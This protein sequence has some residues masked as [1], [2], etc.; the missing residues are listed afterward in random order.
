[1]QNRLASGHSFDEGIMKFLLYLGFALANVVML[2][3]EYTISLTVPQRVKLVELIKSDKEAQA[4]FETLKRVADKALDD[5]P[6]PIKTIQ[7]EGK[8]N[9]DPVKIK[10]HESLKDTGKIYALGY[11][12]AVTGEARYADKVREFVLAWATENNPTGDPIDETSLESLFVAYDLTR[13]SYSSDETKKAEAWM[14]R[15]A[16]AEISH[17]KKNAINN[18]QS[19]RL[20]IVGLVG[21]ALA[22]SKYINYAVEGYKKQMESNLKPDG[23]S[24]DFHERDAL[25]YHCYDLEPLLAL[26]MAAQANGTNL[27]SQTSS[28][29]ASLDKSVKFLV[30]YC[31]G[32]KTHPEFVNSKV[33]FD[34]KRAESGDEHYKAGHPFDPKNGGHTLELA[35]FFDAGYLPIYAQ[36]TGHAEP[37]YPSWQFVLN[38]ARK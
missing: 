8:L 23:S 31:T 11:A 36:A 26:A 1:M 13:G 20:K 4:R 29:G 25:H 5:K 19:H 3:G 28:G 34:R 18:W 22:D 10:T 16:D 7:T 6:N 30:P 12:F 14:R 9:S 32:A 21:Y 33:A 15:V 2:A 24:F 38:A 35:S 37:K 27:Y 17:A